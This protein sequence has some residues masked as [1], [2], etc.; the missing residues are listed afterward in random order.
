[1]Q[2]ERSPGEGDVNLDGAVNVADLGILAS[3]WQGSGGW[4]R[5][6]FNYD[7]TINVADLGMLS[8]NWQV[9]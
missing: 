6:D 9:S 3:N 1:V 4:S 5:G 8:T 2:T 7:G